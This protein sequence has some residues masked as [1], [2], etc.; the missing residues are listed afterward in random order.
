[1]HYYIVSILYY[2]VGSIVLNFGIFGLLEGSQSKGISGSWPHGCLT[3]NWFQAKKYQSGRFL[4]KCKGKHKDICKQ[5]SKNRCLL[6][7]WTEPSS[8]STGPSSPS[9]HQCWPSKLFWFLFPIFI[10]HSLPFLLAV[11]SIMCWAIEVSSLIDS[12][13]YGIV[14]MN[15]TGLW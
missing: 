5:Q 15:W 10:D 12:I 1:M 6:W 11:A 14:L 13:C 9:T 4:D 3:L 7:L 2:T 8:P